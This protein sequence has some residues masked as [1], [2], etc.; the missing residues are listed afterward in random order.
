MVSVVRGNTLI[1]RRHSLPFIRPKY[2]PPPAPLSLNDPP[3][4]PEV[5]ASFFSYLV[6]NW[7][8]PMMALGSARP[9][10]PTDLWKMDDARSAEV[11]SDK[12]AAAFEARQLKAKEYNARLADP[13]TPLPFPQRW[14]YPVMPHREK[15]EMDYRTKHGKKKASLAWSLSDT[16]G[17]FFW[18]GG[19]IKVFG[20]TATACSP[21]LIRA[22]ITFSTE[23]QI[24]QATNTAP[25]SVGRGVGMAIGLLCLLLIASLSIHHFFAREFFG[26]VAIWTDN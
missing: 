13:K 17:S 14:L 15:R 6:F 23:W 11:L 5:T 21:L 10:Q 18:L 7:V 1:S 26:A 3:V 25:P 8:S 22:L 9:L 24:A 4:T 19:A 12:L 2:P 20:D 16:F